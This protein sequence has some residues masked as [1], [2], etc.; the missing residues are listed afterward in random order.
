L[1]T[2]N[3]ENNCEYC[4]PASTLVAVDEVIIN[5]MRDETPLP[6][7]PL[8]ALHDFTFSVTRDRGVVHD[9]KE[10]AFLDAG[11]AQ[12]TVLDVVLGVALKV[13]SNDIN[14]LAGTPL[15]KSWRKAAWQKNS[16]CLR[17]RFCGP[18]CSTA[19]VQAEI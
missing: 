19:Q 6:T 14:H 7:T 13:V 8:E 16:V 10:Q 17:G 18:T 9:A 4:V 15:D 5:A 12:R 2:S 1:Q 11:Y 3:V